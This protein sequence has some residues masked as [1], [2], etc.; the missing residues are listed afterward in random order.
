MLVGHF[1]ELWEGSG[2]DMGLVV[3]LRAAAINEAAAERIRTI[4][5]EQVLPAVAR[6]GDPA[7]A[8]TRA[9]MVVGQL[10]G[11]ALCQ[12]ILV[13]PPVADMSREDIVENLAPVMALPLSGDIR[14]KSAR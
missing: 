6:I 13:I 14:G 2:K 11:L 3:L 12:Y 4:F 1:L 7:A 9:G 10:F 5:R 8:E